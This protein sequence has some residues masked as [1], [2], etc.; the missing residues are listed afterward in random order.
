MRRCLR[1]LHSYRLGVKM[2]IKYVYEVRVAG[3]DRSLHVI[4]E[5]VEDAENQALLIMEQRFSSTYGGVW[6]VT[7]VRELF[8]VDTHTRGEVE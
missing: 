4:A 6:R 8:E 5:H 1:M 3:V 2:E 7:E